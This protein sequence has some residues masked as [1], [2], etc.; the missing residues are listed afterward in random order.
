[1]LGVELFLALVVLPMIIGFYVPP[2]FWLPSLWLLAFAAWWRMRSDQSESEPRFE[3]VIARKTMRSE[4][5]R[6]ALRLILSTVILT[7]GVIKFAPNRLFNLPSEKPYLWLAVMILY[8]VLSVYPQEMIYRRY[9][10]RRYSVLVEKPWL[11]VAVS[12]ALFGWMHVI[13]RNDIA[14]VLTAIGGFIFADTYRRT[15]SLRL[16]CLEH[17]LY[18]QLI[19]TIGLG[20]FFYHGTIH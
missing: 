18:G 1:M 15:G 11:R 20:E 2:P 16:T 12:A 13:F 8:P 6:I 7:V 4:I 10:F 9:F 19:F 14:I 5:L 3:P 17:S